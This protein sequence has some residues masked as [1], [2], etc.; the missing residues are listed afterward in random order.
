MASPGPAA[1]RDLPPAGPVR[2]RLTPARRALA[3]LGVPV[4]GALVRFWWSSC[5]ITAVIDGHHLEQAAASGPVI[6]VY[7]HAH[8]LFCV[9]HLLRGGVPGLAAG[10]LVSPSVDGEIPARLAARHGATVI[11][12]S[13]SHTGLRALRDYYAALQQGVSPAITPDGPHGP[14][15]VCKPGAVLLSQLSG[16]PVVP[17]ACHAERAWRLRT[18][19]RFVLP[20]P[21]SRVAVAVG[22]PLQVPRRL[23]AESLSRWQV[24]LAAALEA[25]HARAAS[26]AR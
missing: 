23:D 11:R 4:G 3:T 10:F 15:R 20:V 5:R 19:D 13:S 16:R 2:R 17:L 21:Y 25:A 12:G 6:P 9:R 22:E 18:W 8:Q 26:A 24:R 1:P 14:R 7:W